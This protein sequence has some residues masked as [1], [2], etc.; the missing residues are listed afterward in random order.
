MRRIDKQEFIQALKLAGAAEFA[1]FIQDTAELKIEFQVP[2]TSPVGDAHN[3]PELKAAITALMRNFPAPP[4]DEKK[5]AHFLTDAREVRATTIPA[6]EP[7]AIQFTNATAEGKVNT[8][9]GLR[10][11]QLTAIATVSAA[12]EEKQNEIKTEEA[13]NLPVDA[14]VPADD[15]YIAKINAVRARLAAAVEERK[16][17]ANREFSNLVGAGG[18]P[19]DWRQAQLVNDVDRRIRTLDLELERLEG[20]RKEAATPGIVYTQRYEYLDYQA[21]DPVATD[22]LARPARTAADAARA[23]EMATAR[24]ALIAA[25]PLAALKIQEEALRGQIATARTAL[26]AAALDDVIPETKPV[27]SPFLR[28]M[29]KEVVITLS[30][31]PTTGAA[32]TDLPLKGK[33]SNAAHIHLFESK[34]VQDRLQKELEDSKSAQDS[35]SPFLSQL[36]SLPGQL[37]KNIK[38][39]PPTPAAKDLFAQMKLG[40]KVAVT[41]LPNIVTL[42]NYAKILFAGMIE[43][44]QPA[45]VGID[46]ASPRADLDLWKYKEQLRALYKAELGI[47]PQV[48]LTSTRAAMPVVRSLA[49]VTNIEAKATAAVA[50]IDAIRT[51][52]PPGSTG[53]ITSA[54]PRVTTLDNDIKAALGA[55]TTAD[56][57]EAIAKAG[58]VAKQ[59]AFAALIS[60]YASVNAADDKAQADWKGGGSPTGAADPLFVAKNEARARYDATNTFMGNAVMALSGEFAKA[61]DAKTHDTVF[62][63]LAVAHPNL[64]KSMNT[65]PF[66]D[67]ILGEAKV[68]GTADPVD[69]RYAGRIVRFSAAVRGKVAQAEVKALVDEYKLTT[70]NITDKDAFIKELYAINVYEAKEKELLEILKFRFPEP[71]PALVEADIKAKFK[72]PALDTFTKIDAVIKRLKEDSYPEPAKLKEDLALLGL[73]DP[74][75]A[76]R[77]S[78][79]F[80]LDAKGTTGGVTT[81]LEKAFKDVQKMTPSEPARAAKS[82]PGALR[83]FSS[84]DTKRY[85]AKAAKAEALLGSANADDRKAFNDEWQTRFVKQLRQVNDRLEELRQVRNQLYGMLDAIGADAKSGHIASSSMPAKDLIQH[86]RATGVAVSDAEEDTI[87]AA[88]VKLLS[89]KEEVARLFEAKRVSGQAVLAHRTSSWYRSGAPKD[90]VKL[91]KYELAKRDFKRCDDEL[92]IAEAKIPDLKRAFNLAMNPIAE[93]EKG[94]KVLRSEAKRIANEKEK[95]ENE[96]SRLEQIYK[97]L[98]KME[99]VQVKL[100]AKATKDIVVFAIP[101]AKII[102]S[103]SVEVKEFQ[104]TDVADGAGLRTPTGAAITA[105]AKDEKKFNSFVAGLGGA[106]S[107]GGGGGGALVVGAARASDDKKETKMLD[108]KAEVFHAQVERATVVSVPDA[109]TGGTKAVTRTGVTDMVLGKGKYP[110]VLRKLDP[111]WAQDAVMRDAFLHSPSPAAKVRAEAVMAKLSDAKSAGRRN[112]EVKEIMR[113]YLKKHNSPTVDTLVAELVAKGTKGAPPHVSGVEATS[114]AQEIVDFYNQ[115]Y[116]IDGDRDKG[117]NPAYIVYV[118]ENIDTI[119]KLRTNPSAA[120][121]DIGGTDLEMKAAGRAYAELQHIYLQK[122][123]YQIKAGLIGDR[124]HYSDAMLVSMLKEVLQNHEGDLGKAVYA[125]LD[126]AL[127][128]DPKAYLAK[129]KEVYQLEKQKEQKSEKRAEDALE[130]RFRIS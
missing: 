24:A 54:V 102:Y 78:S 85:E 10:R 81:V 21:A 101:N 40:Y 86:V 20:E 3:T 119:F 120:G 104:A 118:K 8:R 124:A 83:A 58:L 31:S 36:R 19:M 33:V 76:A 88:E 77:L 5:L 113:D 35:L 121:A 130:S 34:A 127:S 114:V 26:A 91:Q 75:P 13:K 14:K 64:A 95:V 109:T 4:I 100:E 115:R 128:A 43:N 32:A 41:R 51:T 111:T 27:V 72:E 73:P 30:L 80:K 50:A 16:A 1:A 96:L 23:A 57:K 82:V 106:V 56:Q 108:A 55:A 53:S 110:S 122:P 9:S 99:E 63:L 38:L 45:D 89:A 98:K 117:W 7:L 62:K 2:N 94:Q 48:L 46:P 65:S 15:Q 12:L 74:A 93:H 116:F 29:N 52:P 28:Y 39:A 126:S 25:S 44:L 92:K 6:V 87:L 68:P 59:Q 18:S 79:R 129:A 123:G 66:K 22:K 17:L 61:P 47:D 107:A 90:P 71:T 69:P 11:T 84:E 42:R 125:K 70:A 97:P 60:M 112:K 103:A 37:S 105:D 49:A 67:M